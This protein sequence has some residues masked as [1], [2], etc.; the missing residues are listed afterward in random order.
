VSYVIVYTH[1]Q[2]YNMVE[3]PVKYK[4]T[5]KTSELEKVKLEQLFDDGS[6][7]KTEV[8]LFTGQQGLEGLVYIVDR[9]K[10]ACKT[11]QWTEGIEM[12]EGFPKVLQGQAYTYW[13]DEV[14]KT[15][16][17]E[18]DWTL[19]AFQES[20]NM[21]KMSFGGGTLARNHILQ[22]VQTNE[23]KKPRKATVEEHVRRITTLIS[24]ANQSAGTDAVVTKTKLNELLLST[25]PNQWQQNFKL[26]GHT[27]ADMT[28]DKFITYFSEVKGV[29]DSEQQS[30]NNNYRGRG[31]TRYG[32]GFGRF[33]RSNNR[34]G[35]RFSYNRGGRGGRFLYWNNRNNFSYNRY[36]RNNFYR[37]GTPNYNNN[38]NGRNGGRKNNRTA[39]RN[40]MGGRYYNNNNN[41][42]NNYQNYWNE[43]N[44]WSIMNNQTDNENRE[45][46]ET[47]EN[48]I[49]EINHWETSNNNREAWDRTRYAYDPS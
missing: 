9:F 36:P 42:G 4:S 6:K 19:E 48:R 28:T 43:N 33:G 22:Y 29:Y 39:G 35:G 15:F 1:L 5:F 3:T 14:L 40:M 25:M 37:G 49:V 38:Q 24:L 21:L 47:G 41:Q 34:S 44:D 12:F 13:T 7:V 45:N 2:L 11:L 26:S 31:T 8:P 10:E 30:I 20:I 23:C 18:D 32:R 27:I 46:T 16:P 17:T